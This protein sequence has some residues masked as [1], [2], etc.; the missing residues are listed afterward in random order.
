MTAI[1]SLCLAL[2]RIL[3]QARKFFFPVRRVKLQ[4]LFKVICRIVIRDA[5]DRRCITGRTE[6]HNK[7]KC[8]KEHN[9]NYDLDLYSWGVITRIGNPAFTVTI[10]DTAYTAPA[11]AYHQ[12]AEK[13][14]GDYCAFIEAGDVI[15]EN[16]AEILTNGI[17]ICPG[18]HVYMIA[19]TFAN[20][21]KGAFRNF[22]KVTD[23]KKELKAFY[24]IDLKNKYDCYPFTF[25]GT[26]LKTDILKQHNV[27]M[28][29]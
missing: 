4:L 6:D 20:A 18:H 11:E 23:S 12:M 10:D 17:T 5:A 26:I 27:N 21:T 8:H 7:S 24:V 29:E 2:K 3:S 9:C 15:S 13:A 19:K 16:L 14:E 1:L 22:L 28:K 25:A